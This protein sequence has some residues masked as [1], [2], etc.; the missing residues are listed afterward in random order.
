MYD[1]IEYDEDKRRKTLE[2]RGLDFA[3]AG[4]IFDGIHYTLEDDRMD[5]GEK[6][7]ITIGYMS[8]RM[9]VTAWTPRGKAR[10][11][12]SLRKANER[13]QRKFKQYL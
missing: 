8:G 7:F 11:I 10:R 1:N 5:Y 4:Q 13:E 12:I 9:V 2:D 3:N 6:R